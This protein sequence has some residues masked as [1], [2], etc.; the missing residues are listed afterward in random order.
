[1]T[2]SF[3]FHYISPNVSQFFGYKLKEVLVI[4]SLI[5]NTEDFDVFQ[6]NVEFQNLDFWRVAEN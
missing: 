6:I 2:E 1:L 5:L 4:P 3:D